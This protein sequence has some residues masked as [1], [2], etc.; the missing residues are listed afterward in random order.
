[1]DHHKLLIA[2]RGEIAVRIIRTAQHLGLATV[3]IYTPSDALAPHVSLATEAVELSVQPGESEAGPYLD[4]GR[5][6]QVALTHGA[7]LVHPGY[8]F[9]SENASFA[10]AV[11]DAG[12]TFLGP[13]TEVI[14]AMGLKH[15]ARNI[16]VQ[17]GVPVIPG[18]LRDDVEQAVSI[19]R[20]L[21]YPI[22]IKASAGGG[23][24]GMVACSTEDELVK[25]FDVARARAQ[26]LFNNDAVLLER[27]Y[28]AAHHIEVQ[29]FGNGKDKVIH[30]GER[31]CSLQR[32]HQKV[33]KE[34][35]SPFLRD[36]LA[37]RDGICAAAVRLCESM[38]YSSAGTVEFLVD[39][40]S[41]SFFFLE[42]NTR[43]Q[44]EH[45]VTEAAQGSLDLVELMIQ[46][47]I[48]EANGSSLSETALDQ[49]QYADVPD[50][51]AIEV[52]IYAENPAESF[53]P[54]PGVLQLVDWEHGHRIP[55][56]M[57]IDT[58][59][60]TGTTI[61]PFFD[62]LVAKIIVT[63]LSRAEAIQRL[64]GSLRN[65]RVLGPTTNIPY[66]LHLLG[67][68]VMK[69]GRTTTRYLSAFTYIPKALTVLHPGLST[70]VQD[71][72][73]RPTMLRGIPPSGAMDGR[74]HS[75][76]NL[77][78]GNP[79]ETEALEVISVRGAAVR[80]KFWS[81]AVVGVAGGHPGIQIHIDGCPVADMW[82]RVHVEANSVLELVEGERGD[83][84][85]FRTY[86]A[87]HGGFP[88]IPVYLG[89]KSTSMGF[90]G[91]QGRALAAGDQLALADSTPRA[92]PCPF[93]LPASLIPTYAKHWSIRVACGPHADTE[94]LTPEGV[95]K[96]Y[97]MHWTVSSS[98]NR[99]G[100]RLSPVTCQNEHERAFL[101]ARENGGDG[102]SHPSNILDNAYARGS[103]NVN[104]DTPVILGCEGPDMGG[105]V[106]LCAVIQ[107]DMWKLGQ[108]HPGCTLRFEP[109]SWE[110][111]RS[112]RRDESVW[113]KTVSQA[114]QQSS[115]S[116]A[117]SLDS[118]LPTPSE[119]LLASLDPR[120]HVINADGERPKVM[121]R[122][123]GDSAIL[124]EYGP[125]ELDLTVRARIHAFEDAV[126]KKR[127][128]GIVGF[129][130]CI[131]S[132]MCY[133]D[134]LIVSQ[135]DILTA[136]IEAEHS[137]PA[138]TADMVFPGRRITLPI[139]LDDRWNREA[140]K[141]YIQS[142]R[143][144]AVY[145]PS[146]IKYLASNNGLDS[147]Q[148]ALAKLSQSDWLVFGVGFYLACPFLVPIDP[149]ARL[150]GQKMNPSRTFT[151][152]GAIGIAG[153]V[154]AI[155]PIESPGGYQLYGRTIP[156][157]HT[158][159]KGKSFTVEKPWLLNPFDQ[160]RYEPVSEEEY[161]Q[162]ERDF[163]AG[164]YEFRIE[165]CELSISKY[166][167]FIESIKDEV[168]VFR[169]RQ[170]AAVGREEAREKDLLREW[171]DEQRAARA[172][173][174][175]EDATDASSAHASVTA[176][177]SA[178]IWR[179][180]CSVGDV[181]KSADDVLV[182]LEAMK[183]EINITA[184][185]EHVGKTVIGYAKGV[186]EGAVVSSGDAL[187]NLS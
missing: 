24:M 30:M 11:R 114:V 23:G 183:T 54:S 14:T 92:L 2:N 88:D 146:N 12:I 98:S 18:E 84:G 147:E 65:V 159:G 73:G 37:L 140:L 165:P 93:T 16:A 101:W 7:T 42:M 155:Y 71:L 161:E 136:L 39:D 13:S 9:L 59:V 21:E 106:C 141:K 130:P 89:S 129:C 74:A 151:P 139:V 61:T 97:S 115:R 104:G 152:R 69:A 109:I 157:W 126:R 90:G 164:R 111:A 168:H 82:S 105:Y 127:I 77:L 107:G 171:E 143:D 103:I 44:V 154:A 34:T 174:N 60:S 123:A 17:A 4:A 62:P 55:D 170:A 96:F 158:W 87:V 169:E 26:S 5:I 32:R 6:V 149:R 122:Q 160:V 94:F 116:D 179:I 19:A 148:E 85:G 72:P 138:S 58:W 128:D 49:D 66:L 110:A 172:D 22:L 28:P 8:G 95:N 3:A 162:L 76:A 144:K 124:L 125:M 187:I 166:L 182:I 36:K 81:E 132:T 185:Q 153:V 119:A 91:Y 135:Q 25:S 79:K 46:Q 86:I 83:G 120:L 57:R 56:W 133:Y 156:G 68:E 118:S 78:V 177:L 131:R 53:R 100:I 27:Y 186:R 50:V 117:G 35:P 38:N 29:V 178:S 64:I 10:R 33:V 137:L 99:M 40:I 173:G 43:I 15:E 113:I 51:H 150:V 31:E 167:S 48:E 63:A 176:P 112:I 67:S 181:I 121:F 1:M 80:L 70:L 180:K 102:G 145:L 20:R 108:L 75:A 47:G 41:S 184:G 142:T 45:G 163:D 175:T 52:R 134:P